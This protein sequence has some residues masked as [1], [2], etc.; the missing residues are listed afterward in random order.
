MDT[1]D[2]LTGAADSLGGAAAKW[3]DVF[4]GN[5]RQDKKADETQFDWKPVA[6]VVGGIL[7]AA[8]VLKLVFGK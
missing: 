1:L 5:K 4:S 2:S 7:G 8:I 6:W 3:Y